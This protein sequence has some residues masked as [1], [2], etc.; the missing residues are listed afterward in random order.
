MK[1]RSCMGISLVLLRPSTSHR[2]PTRNSTLLVCCFVLLLTLSLSPLRCVDSF[3]WER[4]LLQPLQRACGSASVPVHHIA[5]TTAQ[6]GTVGLQWYSATP[7]LCEGAI[8]ALSDTADG[9]E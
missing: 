8:S 3:P 2:R 7:Q 6:P 9:C 4:R 1:S 5:E